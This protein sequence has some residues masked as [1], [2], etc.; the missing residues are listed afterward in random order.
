MRRRTLFR[1]RVGE[2][3][4]ERDPVLK[5]AGQARAALKRLRPWVPCAGPKPRLAADGHGLPS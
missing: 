4:R 2:G 3:R 5:R 1:R